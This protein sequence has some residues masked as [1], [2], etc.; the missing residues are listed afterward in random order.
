[1]STKTGKPKK[2]S[3]SLNTLGDLSNGAARHIIDAALKAALRDTEDRGADNKVRTVTI[4]IELKKL[5]DESITAAVKAK[6]TL[7]PYLT[8]PT[9]ANIKLDGANV[10]AEFN[11]N[12]AGNPDQMTMG[13]DGE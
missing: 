13:D 5:N 11:P 3:L 6:P 12:S 10:D 1:M 9:I 8:G 2:V 7:P 4:Q